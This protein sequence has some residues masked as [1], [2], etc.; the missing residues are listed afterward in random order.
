VP[1]ADE[2]RADCNVALPL[3]P[4]PKIL[5][6]STNVVGPITDNPIEGMFWDIEQWGI[7]Q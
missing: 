6:R 7:K 5:I 3:D 1:P 4:S 2:I